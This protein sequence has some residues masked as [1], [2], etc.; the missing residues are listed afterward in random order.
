MYSPISDF[1]FD[2]HPSRAYEGSAF[3]WCT[4]QLLATTSTDWDT[5]ARLQN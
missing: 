5:S 2:V 1:S 4:F 3:L